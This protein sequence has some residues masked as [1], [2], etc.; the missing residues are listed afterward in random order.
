MSND[1][2]KE[3]KF[4]VFAGILVVLIFLGSVISNLDIFDVF[5]LIAITVFT[6]RYVIAVQRK[7]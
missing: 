5:Y 3:S 6:I 4:V 1:D 7:K 2:V